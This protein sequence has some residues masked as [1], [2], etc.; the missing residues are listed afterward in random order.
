MPERE[1]LSILKTY[2]AFQSLRAKAETHQLKFR[3][4]ESARLKK[5]GAFDE[6]IDERTE[7]CW[8]ILSDCRSGG[9]HLNEAEEIGL[10]I[11]LLP[12]EDEEQ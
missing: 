2:P 10:P 12:E 3:P 1:R 8:N 9:M 11:I 5:A 4:K 6:I 7:Q